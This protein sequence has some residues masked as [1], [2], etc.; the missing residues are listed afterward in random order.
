MEAV[1]KS[2]FNVSSPEIYNMQ[3]DAFPRVVTNEHR[4]VKLS[5]ASCDF[6]HAVLVMIKIDIKKNENKFRL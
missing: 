6:P 3:R 1:F 4:T 2:S 5:L